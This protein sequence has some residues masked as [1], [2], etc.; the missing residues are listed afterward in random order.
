MY[1]SEKIILTDCDGVMLEWNM[2]FHQWMAQMGYQF[3]PQTEH[4]YSIAK[5]YGISTEQAA[6]CVST[7]NH[8]ARIGWL[9]SFRDSIYYM[10]QLHQRHGYQFAV[11]TSLSD[12]MYAQRL[13]QQNLHQL[14]GTSMF[15][16]IVCLATGADK[17]PELTRWRDSGCWWVEDSAPNA[18]LGAS[19]G[20]RSLLMTHSYNVNEPSPGAQPVSD[21]AHIYRTVTGH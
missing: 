13:R 8:S 4:C 10:T 20:L 18:A 15:H 2:M 5:R 9:P 16:S 6:E 19:L 3:Q 17:T 7:F 21:W 12:C 1:D 11:I 14:F